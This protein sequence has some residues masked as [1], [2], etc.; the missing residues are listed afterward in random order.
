MVEMNQISQMKTQ[1]EEAVEL[2][3]TVI[4]SAEPERCAEVTQFKEE[5]AVKAE[6]NPLY[7]LG[8]EKYIRNFIDSKVKA[9]FFETLESARDNVS[10]VKLTAKEKAA[11]QIALDEFPHSPVFDLQSVIEKWTDVLRNE[12][13]KNVASSEN[14]TL[15]AQTPLDPSALNFD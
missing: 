7:Q 14:S 11:V 6:S 13:L 2:D 10:S 1:W 9:S 8:A 15:T 12:G 4:F 5:F 3:E